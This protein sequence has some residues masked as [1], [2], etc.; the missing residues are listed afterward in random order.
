MNINIGDLV[1]WEI[2]SLS[3]IVIGFDDNFSKVLWHGSS[4]ICLVKTSALTKKK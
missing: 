3:G 1:R 4:D 2:L